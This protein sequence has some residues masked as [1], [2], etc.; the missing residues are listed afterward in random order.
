VIDILLP[1][2]RPNASYLREALDSLLAQ[3]EQRWQL[4]IRDEPTDVDTKSMI[5]PYLRDDRVHFEQNEH[6]LGIG[7]N[8]NACL[9]HGNAPYIQFLFQDDVW[10]PMYLESAISILEN[11]ADVGFVSMEHQYVFEGSDVHKQ[12]FEHVQ[13]TRAEIQAGTHEGSTFLL[14]WIDRGLHPNIIGEPSFVTLRRST[15][16]TVGEFRED[17][18]QNLDSEYWMRMLAST[19]WHFATGEFGTFRVHA[20][21]ASVRQFVAGEGIFDRLRMLHRAIALVQPKQKVRAKTALKRHRGAM[22]EKFINRYGG[23]A[24]SM[25]E[26]EPIFVYLLRQPWATMKSVYRFLTR[27]CGSSNSQATT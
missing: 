13:K 1:T 4:W 10:N 12:L 3:T 27:R 20:D 11:N 18:A 21:A 26:H 7:G 8:W 24:K 2:Y 5:E 23:C 15:V 22:V 16:E 14:D 25:H 17:M 19:N 6:K 9:R